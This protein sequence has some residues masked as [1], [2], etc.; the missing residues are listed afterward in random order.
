[1]LHYVEYLTKYHILR[2]PKSKTA[3]EVARELLNIF[4]D[5]GAPHFLQSDN[6][7]EFTTSVIS[8][9]SK[10]WPNLTLVNGRPRHPQSQGCVERSNG[11]M[12]N[13]IQSWMR[14]NDTTNWSLGIRFIK[15]QMNTTY[16]DAIRTKPYMALT[17]NEPHCG[18]F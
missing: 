16:H 13:K 3:I 5:F 17:G 9:L 6:G 11:D 2:P 18:L 10:L 15:W 1:M 14:D 8:E 7:R 4:L 12:K